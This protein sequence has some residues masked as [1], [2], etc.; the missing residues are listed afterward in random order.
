MPPVAV[1]GVPAEV[2]V[3]VDAAVASFPLL[4]PGKT[5]VDPAGTGL[6][7]LAATRP[8]AWLNDT[9]SISEPHTAASGRSRCSSR[10]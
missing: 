4:S 5:T 1:V 10:G 7:P 9:S 3:D 8:R 2:R 6:I